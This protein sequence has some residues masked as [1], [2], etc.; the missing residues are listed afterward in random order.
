M[1]VSQNSYSFRGYVLCTVA[2]AMNTVT[3]DVI[4]L[5]LICT[6]WCQEF[7]GVTSLARYTFTRMMVTVRAHRRA[8]VLISQ[9]RICTLYD[10]VGICMW[11]SRVKV[12]VISHP[13]MTCVCAKMPAEVHLWVHVI[14]SVLWSYHFCLLPVKMM[15]RNLRET[16][17][18][19][20]VLVLQSCMYSWQ[21][22]I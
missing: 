20:H 22:V 21:L 8:S 19:V 13:M 6:E 4:V 1:C 11:L 12:W 18:H 2:A 5:E 14:V 15:W 7:I 3:D 17:V 16:H 9:V 10:L